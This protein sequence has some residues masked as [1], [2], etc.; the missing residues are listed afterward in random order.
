MST[1]TCCAL[2]KSPKES[3]Q[4]IVVQFPIIQL[5]KNILRIGYFSATKI[6]NDRKVDV[7]KSGHI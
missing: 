7:G 2:F 1:V 6:E 5:I 4:N 3:A